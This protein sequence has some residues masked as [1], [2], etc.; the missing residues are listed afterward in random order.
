[1]AA[2]NRM[3]EDL[4]QSHQELEARRRSMEILLANINAG[5]VAL[6]REGMVTTVNRAAERLLGGVENLASIGQDYREVFS[7]DGIQ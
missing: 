3:T 4:Q 1:M 7:S 6:D 2:F 5:V